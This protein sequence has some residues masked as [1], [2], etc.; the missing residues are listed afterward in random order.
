MCVLPPVF[1]SADRR[2]H[3]VFVRSRASTSLMGPHH[4]HGPDNYWSLPRIQRAKKPGRRGATL[5][6]AV[7][8]RAPAAVEPATAGLEDE[9]RLRASLPSFGRGSAYPC[10]T[11]RLCCSPGE[12]SGSLGALEE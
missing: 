3:T 5:E 1:W 9:G 7:V 10:A 12:P 8:V 6:V 11:V 2:D 4:A